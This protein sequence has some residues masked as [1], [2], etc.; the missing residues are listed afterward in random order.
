M[1]IFIRLRNKCSVDRIIG[2]E[3]DTL[4]HHVQVEGNFLI[5]NTDDENKIKRFEYIAIDD[6]IRIVNR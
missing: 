5:F 3:K 1:K 4:G 6:A 2:Y